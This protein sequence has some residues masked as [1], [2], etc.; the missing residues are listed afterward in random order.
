MKMA[1]YK[2]KWK[3]LFDLSGLDDLDK[4]LSKKILSDPKHPITMLILYIYSMECFIYTDLN[5]ACRE[6]DQSKIQY[7]GAYAAA[8]SYILYY[9]NTNT[10]TKSTARTKTTLY[11]GLKMRKD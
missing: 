10:N 5:R 4:P 1:S 6:K 7:Y 9:A 8:L 3:L 11:R 2:D